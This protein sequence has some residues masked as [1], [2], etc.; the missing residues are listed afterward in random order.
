MER[1]LEVR[2]GMSRPMHT[3]RAPELDDPDD[4][5]AISPYPDKLRITHCA[6]APMVL[7]LSIEPSTFG[8]N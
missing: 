2:L 6:D 1:S 7:L 4:N 5:L 8:A 3:S